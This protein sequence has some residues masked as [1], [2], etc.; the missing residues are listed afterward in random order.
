M[1]TKTVNNLIRTS[2][3]L[4]NDAR[5]SSLPSKYF[6][7]LCFVISYCEQLRI[8]QYA[9]EYNLYFQTLFIYFIIKEKSLRLN[10]EKLK[11]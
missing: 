2:D 4:Y 5:L 11:L 7:K 1:H 8:V 6:V 3:N 9:S 10:Q